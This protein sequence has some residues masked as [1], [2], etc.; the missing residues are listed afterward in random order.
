LG[1]NIVRR[2][3][4]GYNPEV[5]KGLGNIGLAQVMGKGAPYYGGLLGGNSSDINFFGMNRR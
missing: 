3:I 4:T 5:P 2:V 1:T